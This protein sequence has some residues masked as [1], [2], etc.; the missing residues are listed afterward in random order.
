MTAALIQPRVQAC[1]N[2]FDIRSREI[3]ILKR[4]IVDEIIVS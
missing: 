1:I 4:F 2:T 3:S